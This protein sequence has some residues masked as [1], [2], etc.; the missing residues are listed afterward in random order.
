MRSA[1]DLDPAPAAPFAWRL[2]AACTPEVADWFWPVAGSKLSLK[3]ET[4]KAALALCAGCPVLA[5]CEGF[6]LDN[7]TVFTHIAAGRVWW[8]L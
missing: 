6:E 5:D 3:T 2:R 4:A 7:P 1:Y 8:G